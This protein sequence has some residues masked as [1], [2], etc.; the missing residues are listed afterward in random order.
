MPY[1]RVEAGD[2]IA[3]SDFNKVLTALEK[4]E[5]RVQALE[6]GPSGNQLTII[7][8]S[9]TLPFYR[10]GDPI[11]VIGTNFE[12]TQGN[13]RAFVGTSQVLSFGSG[14]SDT[15]L[16]FV[17]P[18]VPG[19]Q[20]SGTS[21]NLR[22]ANST[23]EAIYSMVLRPATQV[24][25]G[26]VDVDYLAVNPTTIQ[27]NQAATFQYRCTSRASADADF[28]IDAI[29]GVAANQS[30]WQGRL[31]VLVLD[32]ALNLVPSRIIRLAQLQQRQFYVRITQVPSGTN[33]TDFTLTVSASSGGVTGSSGTRQFQVGQEAPLQDNSITI[34]PQ[35]IVSGSGTLSGD[36]LTLLA[37][38]SV[39]VR[40]RVTFSRVP[41][42]TDT[43]DLTHPITPSAG[44]GWT[45]APFITTPPNYGIAPGDI[46]PITG[47]A[48]R[49]PELTIT[50]DATANAIARVDVTYQRQGATANKTRPLTL[51]VG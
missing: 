29:I 40:F 4:L 39:R 20:E 21:A 9:P 37:G 45:V 2:L 18:P 12:F 28:L 35:T 50:A 19:V 44:S 36:T 26:N 6:S 16:D 43:Y 38:Q 41:D 22:I 49:F 48:E 47:V 51:S 30:V 24:L 7:S 17:I 32:D 46:N 11:S 33:G 31:V 5:A 3:A 23:Q 8:L 27:E 42:G 10:I 14:S 34:E 15:Q 13:T 1:Q 25:F